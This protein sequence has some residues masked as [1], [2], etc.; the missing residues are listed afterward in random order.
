MCLATTAFG[1]DMALFDASF[2]RGGYVH[3]GVL[4]SHE[5]DEGLLWVGGVAVPGAD[6][7]TELTKGL[8]LEAGINLGNGLALSVSGTT[9]MTSSNVATGTIA[10]YGN[11]GDTTVGYYALTAHFHYPVTDRLQPYFGGGVGYMHVFG[12]SDGVIS[13]LTLKPALGAVL[14]AGVDYWITDNIGVFADAKRFFL[15]SEV[16]GSLGPMPVLARTR[17]DPW[18]ISAG[19]SAHF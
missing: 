7:E 8:G 15:D 18:I 19:I 3:L 1:Q 16:T 11:L 2:L 9:P 4:A 10:G 6:Y 12:T 5:A 17:V 14:Q 13:D